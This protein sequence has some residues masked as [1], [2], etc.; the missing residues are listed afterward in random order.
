MG[1]VFLLQ[2]ALFGL[3]Q[4]LR[5]Q[6]ST[7]VRVD[8]Q[9]FLRPADEPIQHLPHLLHHL[10]D[11][12]ALA[13]VLLCLPA[14]ERHPALEALL[15]VKDAPPCVGHQLLRCLLIGQALGAVIPQFRPD[16]LVQAFVATALR[17]IF[18]RVLLQSPCAL[19]VQRVVPVVVLVQHGAEDVLRVVSEEDPGRLGVHIGPDAPVVLQH[20]VQDS[21]RAGGRC[22]Q[23][24]DLAGRVALLPHRTLG[25]Y[26]APAAG[27]LAAKRAAQFGHLFGIEHPFAL[28]L[29]VGDLKGR[30][31]GV[32]AQDVVD[33]RRRAAHAA[34]QLQ[35]LRKGGSAAP[36]QPVQRRRCGRIPVSVH[37]V[38]HIFADGLGCLVRHPPAFQRPLHLGLP[39]GLRRFRPESQS[40]PQ[41]GVL[42]AVGFNCGGRH[43]THVVRRSRFRHDIG[44]FC[45]SILYCL[46][47]TRSFAGQLCA[48]YDRHR[49][50]FR[51]LLRC[52][53]PQ[54]PAGRG[55][56]VGQRH[57]VS[58]LKSRTVFPVLGVRCKQPDGLS[59]QAVARRHF[60]K[61]P[62]RRVFRLRSSLVYAAVYSFR[63]RLRRIRPLHTFSRVS[64]KKGALLPGCGSQCLL[65]RSTAASL[66][67]KARH[68]TPRSTSGVQLRAARYAS[69][70]PFKGS[71]RVSD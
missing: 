2:S 34:R 55:R 7:V 10:V 23:A 8:G 13:C 15:A 62:H 47:H 44:G 64:F 12:A 30:P 71:C 39:L 56:S 36:A 69:G 24:D 28:T 45:G 6:G 38:R 65:R 46:R 25:V 52:N 32:G 70:S 9:H 59:R 20:I 11:G 29:G 4:A 48:L 18:Q 53:L 14:L 33:V 43:F 22:V 17:Q 41:R 67:R 3:G 51:L 35:R 37:P 68:L 63:L 19:G 1:K 66:C 31:P 54:H 61:L 21:I 49:F 58:L 42:V 40:L 16:H 50:A 26:L 27:A 57:T 5:F 60:G